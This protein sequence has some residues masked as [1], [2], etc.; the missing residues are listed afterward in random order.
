[1][2]DI[3]EI[4]AH[5][6]SRRKQP[7]E[8]TRAMLSDQLENIAKGVGKFGGHLIPGYNAGVDQ[9]WLT[10]Q[11]NGEE[12]R[13]WYNY[14]QEK[15]WGEI[16]E[17]NPDPACII[18]SQNVKTPQELILRANVVYHGVCFFD[19]IDTGT[20]SLLPNSEAYFKRIR[21]CVFC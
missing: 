9:A 13:I 5:L 3:T 20:L 6:K 8:Q 11:L 12:F 14:K 1:M 21:E 19:A 10:A 15:W 17:V 2:R 7:L 4:L 18:C 16:A